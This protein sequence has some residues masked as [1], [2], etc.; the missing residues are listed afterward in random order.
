MKSVEEDAVTAVEEWKRVSE[1]RKVR[2]LEQEMEKLQDELSTALDTACCNFV[3][4][5]GNL[6]ENVDVDKI[7]EVL[8]NG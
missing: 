5:L 4:Q 8:S 2:K 1:S 7:Y 6:D 3:S